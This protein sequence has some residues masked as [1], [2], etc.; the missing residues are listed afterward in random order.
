LRLK[1]YTF[2]IKKQHFAKNIHFSNISNV[3]HVETIEHFLTSEEDK[4][5]HAWIPHLSN[6]K[7]CRLHH[8]GVYVGCSNSSH[9]F[10][11]PFR[12]H[13]VLQMKQFERITFKITF[14]SFSLM[15]YFLPSLIAGYGVFY[16][17]FA[18]EPPKFQHV[19][20]HYSH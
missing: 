2:Y 7:C 10:P 13:S 1:F 12:L 18:V 4:Q 3:H 14:M 16:T 20:S 8:R 15:M 9:F 5:L 17:G 6:K 19:S 11:L